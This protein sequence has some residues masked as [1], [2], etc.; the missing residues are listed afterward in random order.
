M[1]K[2]TPK[3]TFMVPY[4][5]FVNYPQDYNWFMEFIRPKSSP[6]VKTICREIYGTWN[7]EAL[8]NFKWN[9]YGKY[10]YAIILTLFVSLFGCFTVAAIPQQYFDYDDVRR[11]LLIASIILGS[12]HLSFEIRQIIHNPKR[13]LQYFGMLTLN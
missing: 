9:T 4:I 5:K 7:G 3:I 1:T 8:I 13:W 6:F 10:Y 2:P 12:I 11:Q